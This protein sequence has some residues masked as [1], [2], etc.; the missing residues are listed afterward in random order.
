MAIRLV[1]KAKDISTN[2]KS[3]SKGD[4]MKTSGT[5]EEA[6]KFWQS[7]GVL[8]KKRIPISTSD[9]GDKATIGMHLKRIGYSLE[10]AKDGTFG[11]YL[12]MHEEMHNGVHEKQWIVALKCLN[13]FDGLCGYESYDSL[14]DLKSEWQL[15]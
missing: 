2:S 4:S 6:M 5:K 1:G 12:G 14:D 15:D 13:I 8:T 7:S 10:T 11:L 9:F 3:R